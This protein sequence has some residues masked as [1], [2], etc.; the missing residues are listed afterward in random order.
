MESFEANENTQSLNKVALIS[1]EGQ[2]FPFETD[3]LLAIQV[4]LESLKREIEILKEKDLL[5]N[6]K[7]DLKKK[8]NLKETFLSWSER[9]DVNCYGKIFEY[10]NI[11]VK[12]I[13][14]FIL[15]GALGATSW[16]VSW[17]ILAYLDYGVVSQIGVVHEQ[18]TEFPA[19]TICD[20]NPFTTQQGH[21]FVLSKLNESKNKIKKA[22]DLASM[23]AADPLYGDQ[24]RKKLGLSLDQVKCIYNG[25]DCKNDLRRIWLYQYGNC[26]QF[27]VGLNLANSV[28]KKQMANNAGIHYGLKISITN[29][30]DS[31]MSNYDTYGF[32]MVVF[33]HNSSLRPRELDDGIF[34]RAGEQSYIGVKRTFI[35]N[36]PWP[37]V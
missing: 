31:Q 5:T 6:D 34:I 19:V 21:E 25:N 3:K 32:G 7:K 26:Y 12:S 17:S 1:T 35:K 13:W 14:A 29:L 37:Y 23:Q 16:F 8:E 33:V 27:N 11:F 28:V 22:V 20:N 10:E 30:T 24:N 15:L 18:P 4:Q 9:S 2:K 36:I